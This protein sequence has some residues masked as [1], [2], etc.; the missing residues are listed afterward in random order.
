MEHRH[1]WPERRCPSITITPFQIPASHPL[2]TRR[3]HHPQPD[4]AAHS[5]D[6][7]AQLKIRDDQFALLGLRRPDRRDALHSVHLEEGQ[8]ITALLIVRRVRDLT[9]QAAAEQDELFPAWRY[10]AVFTD[11]PFELVQ[12]EEQHCDQ[13]I[14]QA[15]PRRLGATAAGAPAVG[16]P[17]PMRPGWPALPSRTTCCAPHGLRQGPDSALACIFR[18]CSSPKQ[19]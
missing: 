6:S 15:G 5:H 11:S 13:V 4:R 17:S 14:I 8:A 1:Q 3:R 7:T 9:K 16:D 10:H 2:R 19:Q 12:A 18:A